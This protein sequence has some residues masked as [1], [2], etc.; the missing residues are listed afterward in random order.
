MKN[1]TID[2]NGDARCWNCGAKSFREK[3]TVRAKTI[4]VLLCITLIGLIFLP[5]ILATKKKLKCNNCGKY[6][7]VA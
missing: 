2:E 5:L 3:R 4:V 1:V 7:D 6:N